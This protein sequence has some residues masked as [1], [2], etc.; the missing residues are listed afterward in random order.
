MLN[1][2]VSESLATGVIGAI[3]NHLP[4]SMLICVD[5]TEKRSSSFLTQS[6]DKGW[7]SAMLFLEVLLITRKYPS[8]VSCEMLF[9]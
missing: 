2:I 9:V 1:L 4:S 6:D 7:M 5:G 8:L 3:S